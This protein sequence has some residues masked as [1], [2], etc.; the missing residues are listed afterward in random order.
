[1]STT[2]NTPPPR[3]QTWTLNDSRLVGQNYDGVGSNW[4]WC[5]VEVADDGSVVRVVGDDVAE[6]EDKLLV[7]DFSWVDDEELIEYTD[8]HCRT[9][10]ALFHRDHVAR[11]Y[12]L[13]GRS[14]T[15]ELPEFVGW[16]SYDGALDVVRE[17]RASLAARLQSV[18]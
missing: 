13:A 17:A 6:P 9:E 5:V 7:R 8:S 11:M 10:R 3:F 16:H 2:I 12:A 14:V 4:G 1:M 15:T 18:P